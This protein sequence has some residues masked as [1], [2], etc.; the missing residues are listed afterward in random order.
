MI[1]KVIHYCWFGGN[2]LPLSVQKCIESWKKF[3]PDY[4]I[5]KWDEENFDLDTCRY[6]REAYDRKK[7]AFVSDYVRFF[8]LY[9]YGG[10]YFDTDVELIRSIDDIRKNGPFFAMEPPSPYDA[11]PVMRIAPGLGMGAEAG[12]RFIKEILTSYEND[13]FIRR[14][15]TVNP[16]TVNTRVGKLI[17]QYTKT[18][19]GS[20]E[21]QAGFLLYPPDFFCPINYYTGETRFTD[22]TRGIH[23]YEATWKNR[24]EQAIARIRQK[25]SEKGKAGRAFAE[26]AVMPLRVK[27][28][29][30]EDGWMNAGKRALKALDRRSKSDTC[31]PAQPQGNSFEKPD[32]ERH[33]TSVDGIS[34][35]V[36]TATFNRAGTLKR[37]FDSLKAQADRNFEWIVVDDGSTDHTRELVRSFEE[38]QPGFPIHYVYQ[39]NGGKHRAINCGVR[40]AVGRFIFIV[41]SDDWLTSDAIRH[42]NRWCEEILHLPDIAGVAGRRISPKG[43]EITGYRNTRQGSCSAVAG[44]EKGRARLQKNQDS[45]ITAPNNQRK[46]YYLTGDQAEIYKKSILLQFPFPEFTGE[47]FISEDSVWNLIAGRGYALRWYAVPIYFCEYKEDGLSAKV[48]REGLE[49]KNFE[50]YSYRLA[51]NFRYAPNPYRKILRLIKFY[52]AQLKKGYPLQEARKRLGRCFRMMDRFPSGSDRR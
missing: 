49:E 6:V 37:L 29:V 2:P 34:V 35:T 30:R 38:E 19:S 47:N 16:M 9:R 10:I 51:V 15:G 43:E 28:R 4:E 52:R 42:V 22:R 33:E 13:M 41:D 26:A 25:Y 3:C 23:H 12:N 31:V 21:E 39:K 8:A 24:D 27:N 17:G 18:Q 50:G 32:G 44:T 46:K 7:W 45:Y 36:L 1:P 11:V 20:F 5:K 40:K 48:R 14:D